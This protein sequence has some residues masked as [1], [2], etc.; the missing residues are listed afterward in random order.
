MRTSIFCMVF[1]FSSILYSR[2]RT[3]SAAKEGLNRHVRWPLQVLTRPGRAAGAAGQ[4]QVRRT[5]RRGLVEGLKIPRL[6][7]EF[8]G[9]VPWLQVVWAHGRGQSS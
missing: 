4:R 7:V 9:V 5:S 8:L 2:N 6:G 3:R 1:R